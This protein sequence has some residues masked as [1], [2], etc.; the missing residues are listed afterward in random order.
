MVTREQE[1]P[2]SRRPHCNFRR[3]FG[4]LMDMLRF[5]RSMSLLLSFFTLQL[6]LLSGGP[7]CARPLV[8]ENAT[9]MANMAVPVNAQTNRSAPTERADDM[10]SDA[11]SQSA[12][13]AAGEDGSAPQP[14]TNGTSSGCPT[15]A[16]CLFAT[17]PA[18]AQV[19][20]PTGLVREEYVP[21]TVLEPLSASVSP[22]L[23]PP[24]A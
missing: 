22:D 16:P 13:V 8:G 2:W 5:I 20:P 18:I 7:D 1:I 19:S 12:F 23:P 10:S 24:R 17:L 21:L 4:Y 9:V 3:L 15:M 14:C 11:A 6:S